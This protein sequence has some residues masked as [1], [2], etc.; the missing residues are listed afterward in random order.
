MDWN[1]VLGIVI[2]L[3][4]IMLVF[5]GARPLMDY[6]ERLLERGRT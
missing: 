1:G 6:L 3:G 5:W 4:I 2:A